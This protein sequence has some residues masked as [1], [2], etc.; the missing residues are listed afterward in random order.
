MIFAQREQNMD[1]VAPR[2]HRDYVGVEFP[3]DR[4]GICA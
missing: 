2:V 1:M 3:K 4:G